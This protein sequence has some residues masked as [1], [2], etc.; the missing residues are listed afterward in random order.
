M[1]GGRRLRSCT[2]HLCGLIGGGACK[3]APYAKSIGIAAALVQAKDDAARAWYLGQAEF[4]PSLKDG[5]VLWLL[6]ETMVGAID[7][8]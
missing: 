2:H 1:E 4:M 6:A 5:K 8:E 7:E 3:H